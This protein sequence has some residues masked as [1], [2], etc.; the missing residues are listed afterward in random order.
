MFAVPEPTSSTPKQSGSLGRAK[1]DLQDQGRSLLPD[2]RFVIV[3]KADHK[4]D[5]SRVIVVFNWNEE[6]RRRIPTGTN[7]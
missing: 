6:L 3:Q 5:A 1:S 2:G 7:P 4:D